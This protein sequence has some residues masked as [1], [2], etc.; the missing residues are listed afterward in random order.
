MKKKPKV[1]VVSY[2]WYP[3]AGV[4]TYRVSRFVKYLQR[5][6]W[7][8][9]ILT[10]KKAAAGHI[11][12]PED[13]LLDSVKVYRSPIFEPS[14]LLSNI[15]FGNTSSTHNPSIF[16]SRNKGSLAKIAVWMRLNILIP[17]AK[18]TW[19]WFA[20]PLGKKLIRHEAPDIIF[21]TSPPPTTHRIAQQLASWSKMPWLADF[22]DPWTNIYYYDDNPLS[23][24]AQKKN[25]QLEKKVLQSADKITVVNHG[26]FD[27]MPDSILSKIQR[28]TN[29]FDPDH[30]KTEE[31]KPQRN[32]LFT[33][34]YFGSLKINQRPTAFLQAL[35]RIENETPEIAQLIRFEFFGSLDPTI[36]KDLKS[37]CNKISFKK[38]SF[39]KHSDMMALLPKSGLLLLSIGNSKNS[40]Y[41]LS[42]KVF[43][44]MISG[45]NVLG[46][47]PTKG[48]AAEVV[49]TTGI[50]KFFER[51]DT[52]GVYAYIMDC[53]KAHERNEQTFNERNESMEKYSFTELSKQLDSVLKK[54]IR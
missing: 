26:F 4:G 41:A 47:G 30:I 34:R 35:G 28:I 39:I 36:E 22:R 29:G 31:N 38:N 27:K 16:Y 17:D 53:F 24:L 8:V 32:E 10:A 21:S 43:E 12:D 45:S 40:S 9:V 54:L 42:T 11:A 51:A 52:N 14:Q 44:Y 5:L 19:K 25:K 48:A 46:I 6:G 2:Y 33:I 20:V 37:I 7:D 23:Q 1:L 49:S 13:P 15:N 18:L 50:G 3:F